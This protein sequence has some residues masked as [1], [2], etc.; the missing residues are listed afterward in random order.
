MVITLTCDVD[1]GTYP[2]IAFAHEMVNGKT[3]T[4]S[5]TEV[6]GSPELLYISVGLTRKIW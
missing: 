5:L 3:N 6:N 2:G 4:T 1:W